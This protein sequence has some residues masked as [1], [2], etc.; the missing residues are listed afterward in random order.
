MFRLTLK[1]IVLNTD[2]TVINSPDTVI[3]PIR[4][5][6]AGITTAEVFSFGEGRLE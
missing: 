3:G 1:N 2:E 5:Y 6:V 4:Y